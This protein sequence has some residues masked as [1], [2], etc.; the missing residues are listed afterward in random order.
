MPE[1]DFAAA[2][3]RVAHAAELVN[4]N[5]AEGD[6]VTQFEALTAAAYSRARARAGSRSP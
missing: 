4:R 5:A 3:A 2:V 6:E 1:A